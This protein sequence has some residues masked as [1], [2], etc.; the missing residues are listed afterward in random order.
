M[1]KLLVVIIGLVLISGGY[2]YA[3]HQK[4]NKTQWRVDSRSPAGTYR[5]TI[6]DE[7]ETASWSYYSHG[8]HRV[9]FS[10]FKQEQSFIENEPLYAGDE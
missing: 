10:V 7:T 4:T 6:Q 5:V 1:G 2:L 9:L 8:S 3:R